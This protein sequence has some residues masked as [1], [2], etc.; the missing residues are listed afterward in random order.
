[1]YCQTCRRPV[2][3]APY[4]GYCGGKLPAPIVEDE[5]AKQA[6]LVAA[7]GGPVC[8]H[9][10]APNNPTNRFCCE[11]GGKIEHTISFD[12][13]DLALEQQ[14]KLDQIRI[15]IDTA[16]A[17]GEFT[18]A[19]LAAQQALALNPDDASLHALLAECHYD[20]GE[21]GPAVTHLRR[22]VELDPRDESY[23]NRLPRYER[24]RVDQESSLAYVMQHHP[25]D[26]AAV[27]RV[28]FTRRHERWYLRGWANA[29]WAM[30]GLL[31]GSWLWFLVWRVLMFG[32][33]TPMFVRLLVF[34]IVFGSAAWAW[35]DA[36]HNEMFGPG[37]FLV[38]IVLWPVGFLIYF[39]CRI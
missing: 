25:G 34:L 35:I 5:E 2:T 11:C 32:P 7:S 18:R 13:P 38:M 15:L 37:W 17:R 24:E 12:A 9:C 21:Y 20:K 6:R 33:D 27:L 19:T 39:I 29:L 30:L 36:A 31:V 1:M 26:V 28:L 22:A 23:R 10:G 16:R 3:D 4:C 14:R 8:L